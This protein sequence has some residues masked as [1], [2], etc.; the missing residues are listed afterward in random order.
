MSRAALI[1]LLSCSILSAIGQLAPPPLNPKLVAAKWP[2]FWIASS[3]APAKGAGVFYLRQTVG[4][5]TL[6]A[7]YWVHVSAD[8]RFLL[9]VNGKYVAEGPARGDLFHW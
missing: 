6:P 3:T 7:H 2:A 4:L 5:D 1:A 9:H 8:N